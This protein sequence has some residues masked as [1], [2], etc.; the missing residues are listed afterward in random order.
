MAEPNNVTS[1]VPKTE[2]DLILCCSGVVKRFPG[3]LALDHVDLEVRR[4]EVHAL[5][6]QNGAGKSTLVKVITGVYSCDEGNIYIDGRLVKLTNPQDAE[7]AGLSII[8]QDQQLVPQFDVKRNVFLG[9]ELSRGGL[10]DFRTMKARTDEVLERIDADF[11]SDDLI[12]NL[13]VGQREQVAIASA[14]LKQPKI[15]ILDEPTASLSRKEAEK[16]FEIIRH[17]KE[18]GV[19]IIYISHHFDEIFE[20]SDRITVLRDGKKIDTLAVVACDKSEVIK[21]MI[22]REISQLYPKKELEKGD[23]VLR[24]E[25]L[26]C[27]DRVNGVSFELRRGEILGVAGIL[28]SGSTELAMALFGVNKVAGGQIILNNR[29][30]RLRSPRMA[31]Q[32]GVALIP[33]DRRNEGI[34]SAMSVKENLSLAFTKLLSSGGRLKKS[35]ERQRSAGIAEQLHIKCA[36]LEQFV[37]TLSGGN[38]QKVVIGKWLVGDQ[39]VFI[40]NQPTTGVDV[41]SKIEIYKAMI[42]LAGKGAGII[43]ISQ[44]FEELLGMCDRILVIANGRITKTF[45]YGE[46]S[47][48]TLLEYATVIS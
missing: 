35:R 26:C 3:N 29:P 47:E 10:L 31:K 20:V 44:D 30:V 27:N 45:R 7:Q 43:M 23:V 22:G 32:M 9:R 40:M 17:L 19:T 24:V 16:L 18:Q 12:C 14:L 48:H 28:G 21:V 38:Q 11:S 2:N 25:D 1:A 36:G 46:A 42:D 34:V 6:G 4:G 5:V 37:G 41:G 13:S 15:L 8:H 39:D 33:E